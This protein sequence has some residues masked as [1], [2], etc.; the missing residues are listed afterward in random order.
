MQ[1]GFLIFV[2]EIIGKMCWIFIVELYFCRII[3][4]LGQER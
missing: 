1:P 4:S 3:F 2:P